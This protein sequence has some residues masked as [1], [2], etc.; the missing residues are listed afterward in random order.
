[1]FSKYVIYQDIGLTCW[2]DTFCRMYEYTK[3]R[4]FFTKD[5][6]WFTEHY[7]VFTTGPTGY[8]KDYILKNSTIPIFYSNRGGRITYHGP[9][10][11]IVYFLLD[12]KRY[13]FSFRIFITAVIDIVLNTLKKLK[14]NAYFNKQRPGIYVKEKK[15]C[16]FGFRIMKGCL[17]HGIALN[18]QMNLHPFSLIV[19]CGI[20]NIVMTQIFNINPNITFNM[21]KNIL[22]A[23][24]L[25]FFKKI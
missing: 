6:I 2:K 12:L 24:M 15:I 4:S 18:I 10:Q 22:I 13:K 14:I 8:K 21:V 1:L 9:G 5:Q 16:S 19:P 20:K 11:Q 17:L 3:N 25:Y 7:P 23:E